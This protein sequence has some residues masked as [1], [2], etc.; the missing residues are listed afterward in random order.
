MCCC[1]YWD[2]QSFLPPNLIPIGSSIFLLSLLLHLPLS[3]FSILS[4]S[5]SKWEIERQR[6]VGYVHRMVKMSDM[7]SYTFACTRTHIHRHTHP[8]TCKG[9]QIK[10]QICHHSNNFKNG[11]HLYHQQ[12]L[13]NLEQWNCTTLLQVNI[14]T[15][16]FQHL[17]KHVWRWRSVRAWQ[18]HWYNLLSSLII[19]SSLMWM[20]HYIVRERERGRER[21]VNRE[22]QRSVY[23]SGF[24]P[25]RHFKASASV[26]VVFFHLRHWLAKI[27]Q[28]VH[29]F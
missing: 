17:L 14:I 26:A 4:P 24:T 1:G 15:V 13:T 18:Q 23:L 3:L 21:K 20:P 10:A 16:H 11:G 28:Y 6:W 9:I 19:I 7:G 25:A 2:W 5:L 8:Q 22:G 29:W 27:P 12:L